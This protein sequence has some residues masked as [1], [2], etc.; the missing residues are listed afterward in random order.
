MCLIPIGVLKHLHLQYCNNTYYTSVMGQLTDQYKTTH[1]DI[2][3]LW[4]YTSLDHGLTDTLRWN[5][6]EI[7]ILC[8]IDAA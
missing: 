3:I 5:E 2:K 1:S 7:K 6:L 4:Q 8:N